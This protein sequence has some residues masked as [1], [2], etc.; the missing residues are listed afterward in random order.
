MFTNPLLLIAGIVAF[1]LV[2]VVAPIAIGVYR[3]YRHRKVV[4]CPRTHGVAEVSLNR[5]LAALAAAVGRPVIRVKN[6]SLWPER[7]GCDEQC[8]S[9]HWPELH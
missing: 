3:Q 4:T 1:G 7:K 9:E 2:A 5:G 8:V 6:C